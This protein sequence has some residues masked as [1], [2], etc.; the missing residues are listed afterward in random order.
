MRQQVTDADDDVSAENATTPDMTAPAQSGG[1]QA[2]LTSFKGQALILGTAVLWGTN[3]PAV[4]YLYASGGEAKLWPCMRTLTLTH[5]G[6]WES[7]GIS[8]KRN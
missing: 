7:A 1:W 6:T 5:F 4:R 2:S 8:C 3:P